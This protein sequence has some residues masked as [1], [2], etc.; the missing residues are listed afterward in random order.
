METQN[1]AD[2]VR[3]PHSSWRVLLLGKGYGVN[4][5]C[6]RH[7]RW[8]V[9]KGYVR[10]PP[11]VTV[12]LRHQMTPASSWMSQ[13]RWQSYNLTL[14]SIAQYQANGFR[15]RIL[16]LQFGCFLKRTLQGYTSHFLFILYR[17]LFCVSCKGWFRVILCV[18]LWIH[19]SK[20]LRL[21]RSFCTHKTYTNVYPW[22]HT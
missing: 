6:L 13:T 1:W 14:R 12:A 11:I 20:T 21:G 17:I 10:F 15:E 8:S 22:K 2:R 7:H 9:L 5:L 16:C 4:S 19:A 18:W 3:T